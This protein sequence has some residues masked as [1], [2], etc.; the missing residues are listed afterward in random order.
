MTF[1]KRTPRSGNMRRFTYLPAILLMLANPAG[2]RGFGPLTHLCVAAQNWK[3][4]RIQVQQLGRP[5]NEQM[6]RESL[7]AGA[8][9]DDLGYYYAS[10]SQ[11]VLLT[12][13]FHYVRTGE[14]VDFLLGRARRS[15]DPQLYA[16]ALGVM[17][18]YAA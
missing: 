2:L 8:L 6:I 12:N 7:F 16:F 13:V 18:H 14:F 4:V 17:S 1:R 9:A 10:D 15:A 5:A 3:L 11:L